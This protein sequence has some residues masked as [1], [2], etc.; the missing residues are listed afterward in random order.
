M[1]S[2]FQDDLFDNI[3]VICTRQDLVNIPVNHW[4]PSC[5]P[6]PVNALVELQVKKLIKWL[7]L[8][9]IHST[10]QI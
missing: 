3:R 8:Y 10:H 2:R 1:T 9:S 6:S 5:N 4:I 7:S